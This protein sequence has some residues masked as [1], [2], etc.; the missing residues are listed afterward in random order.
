[1][2]KDD[3]ATEEPFENNDDVD[4]AVQINKDIYNKK[5]S[6]YYKES[7]L[8]DRIAYVGITHLTA[9]YGLYLAITATQW[10]TNL[11]G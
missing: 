1:M 4:T 8:F 7:S 10:K 3:V 11:F 6:K 9:S 2:G 5:Y